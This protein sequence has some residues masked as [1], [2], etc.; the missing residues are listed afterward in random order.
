LFT[1]LSA[2]LVAS[3]EY[4]PVA[5]APKK[6]KKGKEGKEDKAGLLQNSW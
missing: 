6:A 1:V 4:V 2:L 3:L 5:A